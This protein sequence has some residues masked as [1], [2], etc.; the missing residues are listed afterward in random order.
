M[1]ARFIYPI[2]ILVACSTLTYRSKT[3]VTPAPVIS[4][5]LKPTAVF[6]YKVWKDTQQN[7]INAH[8]GGIVF[9]NG[10]YYWFGEHKLNFNESPS[11]A[12]GGI[13]CYKS[14]DLINWEDTGILMPVDYDNANSDIAFGCR[15]QWPK[16]VYNN[17]T[18]KY[19]AIFKLFLKGLGVTVGYNI[20]ATA[21]SLKGPYTYHS[22]FLGGSP[23]NGAGDFALVK[24]PNGNLYHFTVNKEG[25]RP[26]V[27]A[28]M[29]SDYLTSATPYARC[30]GVTDNIESLA[31]TFYNGV[32]HLLASGSSG[33][34][35]NPCRDFPITSIN[36]PW[37]N[38]GNP[39][40]GVNP[41]SGFG[42]EKTFGGQSAF[43]IQVQGSDP[44]RFIA[45]MDVWRPTQPTT[46][47]YIWLPF[48][49]VNNKL[50]FQW[51]DGWNMNWY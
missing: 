10:F 1:N 18:K 17:A 7:T 4:T 11:L 2:F 22:K 43:I 27:Y 42:P 8:S 9:E 35:P 44:N 50:S 45:M 20:V 26:F 13:H 40:V 25:N 19:V 30:A 29:S 39:Y 51:L 12:D 33:W 46:S 36:G 32:Y 15:I 49:I 16:I 38:Q 37:I 3:G 34:N 31:I 48:K 41:L 47:A 28:K 6:P 14:Q 5:N 23:L 21:D 24:G